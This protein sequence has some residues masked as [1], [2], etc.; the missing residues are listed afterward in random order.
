[1]EVIFVI[2]VYYACM[3]L[4]DELYENVFLD[5]ISL[6]FPPF[7]FA[8]RIYYLLKRLF[9]Y[10]RFIG[11]YLYY[12]F[13][14]LTWELENQRISHLQNKFNR[15]LWKYFWSKF[16]DE[17]IFYKTNEICKFMIQEIFPFYLKQIN[18]TIEMNRNTW[19]D[20]GFLICSHFICL[21]WFQW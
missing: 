5:G 10:L 11:I 12:L 6:R 16:Y 13:V 18:M 2:C 3:G 21:F 19:I 14:L 15:Y 7:F 9:P 20:Q 4:Y 1:M 17:E 8:T